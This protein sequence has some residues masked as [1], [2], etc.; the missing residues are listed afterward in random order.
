MKCVGGYSSGNVTEIRECGETRQLEIS[1]A[2][3]EIAPK[4]R[5]PPSLAVLTGIKF[6]W[7]CTIRRALHAP[8]RLE[9]PRNDVRR[10]SRVM[11]RCERRALAAP[12]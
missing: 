8:S 6:R 9:Q 4:W 7:T 5:Q 1:D 12:N 3:L 2:N 11:T 10:R